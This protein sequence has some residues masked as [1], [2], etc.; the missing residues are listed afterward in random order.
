MN[1]IKHLFTKHLATTLI[2]GFLIVG[3]SSYISYFVKAAVT[4]TPA[5]GGSSISADTTGGSFTALTGP[6]ITESTAGEVDGGGGGAGKSIIL[7]VPSGFIFNT[8]STV[9]ATV[10]DQ[11]TCGGPN[12]EIRLTAGNTSTQTAI[13][14]TTQITINVKTKSSGTCRGTITY[15][16]VEVSPT[17]GTP[18]ASGNITKNSSSTSAITGVTNGVTNFGT[19]TEVAGAKTQLVI[20]TQPSVIATTA[21]DFVTKPVVAVRDQFG[22]TLTFDSATTVSRAVVLSTQ[23]CGGTAGS[24]TLSSTPASGIAVTSGVMTY[25][26]M[27]YSFAESIKICFTSSGIISALSDAIVVSA[28]DATP[29]TV[30]SIVRANPSP[31]AASSVDFTVTFSESVTGVGT[32]DFSLTTTGVSGASV[33]SVSAD[34]GITRTVTVNT[35]TGSGTIRLDVTDDD[36][37]VDLSANKLGGDGAGNGNFTTGE[38]YTVDKTAP[39]LVFTDDV[40]AGPASSDTIAATW[41]D[42]TVMKWRYNVDTSCSTTAGDYPNSG[43]GITT[44][45]TETNNG[46]F[47]CLYGEDSLG[48]KSTLAS[49]NDINIDAAGPTLMFTDNVAAGP[50]SSDTITADWGDATVRKWEYDADGIC[51]TTNG[52]YTKTD[53]DSITQSTETNNG[54]FICLYG[55]DAVVNKSTLVSANDIN[56]DTTAPT[57]TAITPAPLTLTDSNVGSDSFVV[58]I[59]YS[60]AMDGS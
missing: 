21:T 30:S 36:T 10:T 50:V 26:A 22:N 37:I 41:G 31:T 7:D 6:I 44:Q 12:K 17:A 9:I 42:A 4:V 28:A 29:P 33:T 24:G 20:T 40:A 54:M 49:A 52:D 39:V 58:T 45:T 43:P 3:I 53:A 5:T 16:G 2:V 48:N 18:L 19:L 35:G 25:T 32:G 8:A 60:E 46:K 23:S 57:I 47:I 34:S 27:Q 56:I 55:E 38:V 13:V 11:G 1:L 14:T 59:D 15:T 51:S